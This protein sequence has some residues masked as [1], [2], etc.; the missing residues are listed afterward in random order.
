MKFASNCLYWKCSRIVFP[1]WREDAMK[2]QWRAVE[3]QHWT[4]HR[5]KMKANIM[6]IILFL[7]M[8]A[9]CCGGYEWFTIVLRTVD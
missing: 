6:Y 7:L 9:A 2:S 3:D 4:M 8:F 5:R 1:G